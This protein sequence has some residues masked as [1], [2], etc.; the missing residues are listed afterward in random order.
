MALGTFVAGRYSA[1]YDPPGATAAAD[2]GLSEEGYDIRFS[3]AKE[4]INQTDAY[5]E[6]TIDA[7]FRGVRDCFVQATM[8]EWKAGLLNALWPYDTLAPTGATYLSPGVIARLDS[9]IAGILIFTSTTGTPAVSAPA[10]MTASLA[11]LAE[12]FDLQW[13]LHSK[14]RKMPIRWRLYPYSDTVIKF[15]TA[16]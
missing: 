3:V 16:T 6:M 7:I 13:A 2:V 4:L 5:G 11:C 10:T 8:L 15:F 9:N 1:T 12:N 14:L